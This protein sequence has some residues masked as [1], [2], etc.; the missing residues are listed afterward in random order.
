MGYMSAKGGETN[1]HQDS[2][3][4]LD[5]VHYVV[6]GYNHVILF[7][8]LPDEDIEELKKDMPE[9]TFETKYDDATDEVGTVV[10]DMRDRQHQPSI[11][12]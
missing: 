9:L 1:F 11:D 5:A 3:G 7:P 8:W 4:C 12:H 2:E 10:C 6:E